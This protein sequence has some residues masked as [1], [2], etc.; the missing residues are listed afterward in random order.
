MSLLYFL[1]QF[2]SLLVPWQ[3]TILN[4]FSISL[5]FPLRWILFCHSSFSSFTFPSS[6]EIFRVLIWSFLLHLNVWLSF[7]H[8]EACQSFLSDW[9]YMFLCPRLWIMS[10]MQRRILSLDQKWFTINWLLRIHFMCLS[11][12][13][14]LVASSNIIRQ[15]CPFRARFW[16]L[17]N[18]TRLFGGS[19]RKNIRCILIL[20]MS[21]FIFYLRLRIMMVMNICF[22][23]YRIFSMSRCAW[24]K[25]WNTRLRFARLQPFKSHDLS[26]GT[27]DMLKS[28]SWM[29]CLSCSLSRFSRPIENFIFRFWI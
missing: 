4:S 12:K 22:N 26:L 11:H 13:I 7:I 29:G 5:F 21:I 9:I 19:E 23:V 3:F 20:I 6:H 15:W 18:S 10:L 17:L 1:F 2:L 27:S 8:P 14:W 24:E 25:P 28:I 16:S